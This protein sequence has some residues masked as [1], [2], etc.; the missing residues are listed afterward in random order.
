MRVPSIARLLEAFPDLDKQKAKL[1][2]ELGHAVDEGETLEHLIDEN[3]P[4]T[5]KY[6]RKMYSNPYNSHMWR[7]TVALHAMNVVMGTYGVEALGPDVHGPNPPPYEYLNTG[8]TYATTLIYRR[9]D[10]SLNIGNWGDIV[11]HHP[12]W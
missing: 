6:V 2:R 5:S 10:D 4:E 3:V 9:R 12:K 1:I 7:V 8:D 11:E